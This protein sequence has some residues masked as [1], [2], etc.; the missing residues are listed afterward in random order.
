MPKN[1]LRRLVQIRPR[2]LP[3]KI[4]LRLKLHGQRASVKPF[5]FHPKFRITK[6][7]KRHEIG[8]RASVE[9]RTRV[10]TAVRTMVGEVMFVKRRISMFRSL[11]RRVS[12]ER[13]RQAGIASSSS[14]L[15][16]SISPPTIRF[17]ADNAALM[18][19]NS[20]NNASGRRRTGVL[21]I[22][23]STDI[24]TR[25]ALMFSDHTSTRIVA[26]KPAV[27]LSFKF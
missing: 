12:I 16:N 8:R 20:F 26:P 1:S 17:I 11:D 23:L 27:H 24:L 2:W 7:C 5:P 15:A 25:G 18:V 3:L 21:H 19:S 6:R 13:L 10:H 4:R 14:D 9:H 22:I